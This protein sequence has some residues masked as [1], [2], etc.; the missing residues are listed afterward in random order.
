MITRLAGVLGALLL[1]VPAFARPLA[2]DDFYRV[3]WA[4]DPRIS[5]DGAWVAY[6]VTRQLRPIEHRDSAEGDSEAGAG[7]SDKEDQDIWLVRWNGRE[8]LQLTNSTF[9]EHSAR[10]S[11]DGKYIAFLSDRAG[12]KSGDQIWLLNRAGG[13]ARQLSHFDGG[14][15]SFAWSPDGARIVFSAEVIPPAQEESDT[16]KP[17]VI[18]R[19]QFK[20]DDGG[21]LRGERTHLFLLDVESGETTQLTDG[22]FDE[23]QPTWSPDGSRVAFLSK[24][25][26]EP[27]AHANWD[28]Y[29]VDARPDSTPVQ[30]TTNPGT[31]GD[32]MEDWSSRAPTFSADGKAVAY[33]AAGKPEDL[34]YSLVQVNV[35]P[36]AGGEAM[37]PIAKLDRQ[38]FDPQWSTDGR[39]IYFRVEEEQSIVLARMRLRDGRVER[40]TQPGAVV[41]EFDL[42]AGRRARGRVVAVLES[43][44][45]PPDI[46]AIENGKLRQLSHHNDAWLAEVPL[47][48]A[49]TIQFK[50]ADDTVIQGLMML[51]VDSSLV[52][53][54]P[55]LL[56]LHGGPVA[57][58]QHEFDFEW[59]LLAA[60]GYVIVGPNPRGSSG[61]GY[62]FQKMLFGQ[63]GI[64]DV[65]DV[66]AAADYAVSIG[67]ADPQ[68]LGI[69][70]WSYGAI[71]TNYVI[72]ADNRFKAAISGAGMG[73]MLAGYGE[74]QYVREWELELGLPWA[75]TEN[76]LRVSAPFLHAD[77]IATPTLFLV[78]A[79]DRNVPPIGSEQMYQALR[80]LRVPTQL[81]IYPG[82]HHGF[83]RP[84]F[85]VDRLQRY[86]EWYGRYLKTE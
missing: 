3:Q 2:A 38:S 16:P 29:L 25:G 10:W 33:V 81:V 1:A 82:E 76:W 15:S 5:P 9:G 31:D 78:G 21:Y 73:N 60:N 63:T 13:E 49:R 77:R 83:S 4:S 57:Q 48:Q 24:R 50:S 61:R 14:I 68:R 6:T 27:D 67:I 23:L 71:L 72:S 12:E 7:S 53:R 56:K 55:T 80:R 58:R 11:P 54:A 86:L 28:L 17:I 19:L 45:R 52:G 36:A 42:G 18:D 40:L 34:W 30:L 37:M 66:L 26:E 64:V 62:E 46:V 51:P 75:H 35:I 41:S 59:Q 84:S 85:R 39:W 79:E 44:D 70:G 47:A 43:A 32:P 69:G 22:A 20:S 74:D 8:T 65:P